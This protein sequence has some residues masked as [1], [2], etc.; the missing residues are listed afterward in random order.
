MHRFAHFTTCQ[1]PKDIL[2]FDLDNRIPVVRSD[3]THAA[4][5]HGLRL[6]R[7]L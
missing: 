7:V 3:N 6:A 4:V 1:S 5:L 2:R